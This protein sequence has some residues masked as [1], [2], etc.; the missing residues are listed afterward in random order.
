MVS[1]VPVP[2]A[3]QAQRALYMCWVYAL[4]TL[5]VYAWKIVASGIS[6]ALIN[7][8]QNANTMALVELELRKLLDLSSE[9]SVPKSLKYRHNFCAYVR[10]QTTWK[11]TKR[12]TQNDIQFYIE[13]SECVYDWICEYERSLAAKRNLI[14]VPD[15]QV[16]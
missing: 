2:N 3:E 7:F 1:V 5:C 16:I 11:I 13:R 8:S 12:E 4:R 6:N 9:I 15:L 10:G 14:C